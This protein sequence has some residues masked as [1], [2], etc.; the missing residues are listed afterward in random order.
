[1]VEFSTVLPP[2][3]VALGIAAAAGV[4]VHRLVR[5]AKGDPGD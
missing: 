2:I 5:S 3:L 1:M 4:G